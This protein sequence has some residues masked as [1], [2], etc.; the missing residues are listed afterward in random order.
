MLWAWIDLHA[1]R[2]T[3]QPYAWEQPHFLIATQFMPCL[4]DRG[5]QGLCAAQEHWDFP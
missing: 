3:L 4:Q 5:L 2:F 1:V